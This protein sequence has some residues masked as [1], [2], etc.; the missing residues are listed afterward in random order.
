MLSKLFKYEMKATGRILL[1]VYGAT[2]LMAVLNLIMFYFA[3]I[4]DTSFIS[5]NILFATLGMVMVVM[6]VMLTFASI[7][8][9][10]IFAIYRFKKNILDHEGYLM[11]TLPVTP[12]QNILSKL[13]SAMLYEFIAIVVAMISWFIAI[14]LSSASIDDIFRAFKIFFENVA[15]L[16]SVDTVMLTIE[17]VVLIILS[18]I[19]TNLM[20]YAAMSIGYSSNG[21]KLLKSVGIY[22]GFY[23]VCQIISSI[24]L[25]VITIAYGNIDSMESIHALMISTIIFEIILTLAYGLITY[26]FIKNKLNLT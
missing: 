10:Y 5:G 17:I 11:N 1:P 24:M 14:Y 12:W 21:R 22:V 4:E 9:S 7:T 20:F 18:L 3:P 6:L 23:I 26:Y 19:Y 15:S 2:L 25:T 13:F 8:L 16:M